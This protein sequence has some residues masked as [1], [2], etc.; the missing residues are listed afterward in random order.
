MTKKNLLLILFALGLATVYAVWFSDWFRPKKVKIFHTNRNLHA[1]SMHGNALP[2]LIFGVRPQI[3]FTELKV[4]PL[5]EFETNKSAV[6]VWH[7]DF[8][9][10]L[11]AGAIILLWRA[12]PRDAAGHQRRPVLKPSIANVTYRMFIT[13]GSAKGQHDFELKSAN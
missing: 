11:R 2:S 5:A 9:F 8:G 12:H 4:V 1:N 3:R 10:Q 7:L 13:A 6:A